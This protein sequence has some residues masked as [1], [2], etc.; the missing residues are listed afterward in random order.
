[1][2]PAQLLPDAYGMLGPDPEW[3][4]DV[5]LSASAVIVHGGDR[6]FCEVKGQTAL[7]PTSDTRTFKNHMYAK[8]SN[9]MLHVPSDV[10]IHYIQVLNLLTGYLPCMAAGVL[11]GRVRGYPGREEACPQQ[12]C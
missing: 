12:G 1:M 11:S 10:S 8:S 6:M 3:H 9:I 4:M 7:C 5:V 2:Q